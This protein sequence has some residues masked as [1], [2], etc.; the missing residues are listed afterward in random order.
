MME[1]IGLEDDFIPRMRY[2]DNELRVCYI[3]GIFYR[4]G[5][6]PLAGL[7]ISNDRHYASDG[8]R[9]L[10]TPPAEDGEALREAEAIMGGG[11][12]VVR[13][14]SMEVQGRSLLM[15][16]YGDPVQEPPIEED[17]Y[18]STATGEV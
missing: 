7:P 5:L 13:V 1:L 14:P 16:G 18:I 3:P 11:F 6:Q 17:D 12:A 2:L 15:V 10:V 4:A 8:L 9:A